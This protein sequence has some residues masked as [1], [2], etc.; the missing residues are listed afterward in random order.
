MPTDNAHIESAGGSL[1]EECLNASWFMSLK[2]AKEKLE[3]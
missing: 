2:D 1:R 3:K